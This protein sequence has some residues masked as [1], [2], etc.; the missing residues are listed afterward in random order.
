MVELIGDNCEPSGL[1]IPN[2]DV[3]GILPNKKGQMVMSGATLLI[4]DGSAVKTVTLT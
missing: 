4:Y 1:T 2:N 3:S